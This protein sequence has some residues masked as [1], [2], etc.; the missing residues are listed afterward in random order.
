MKKV[1]KIEPESF[2]LLVKQLKRVINDADLFEINLDTMRVKGDLAVIYKYFKK[3]LIARAT[4]LSLLRSAAKAGWPYI[5]MPN[6]MQTDLEFT[7]LVK[8]KGCT[9]I[10][11]VDEINL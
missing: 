5:L 1:L 6:D 4:T 10:S 2:A 3:P 9:L 8:N 7:T 11:S